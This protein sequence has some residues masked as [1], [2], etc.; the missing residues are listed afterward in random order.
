M[1]NDEL[2]LRQQQLL[3]RS[4]ELRHELSQQAQILTKPLAMADKAREIVH[5]LASNPAW[6]A[7]A[8]LALIV[9][10]PRRT[11]VWAGASG[12]AGKATG[13]LAAGSRIRVDLS[14]PAATRFP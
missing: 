11:L 2:L 8:V 13:K 10:R 4:A 14:C 7:G 6:P 12:G 1:P 9:L 3:T 5:W